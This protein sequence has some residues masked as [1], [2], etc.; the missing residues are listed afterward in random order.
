M[1]SHR[2]NPLYTL[3]RRIF[4]HLIP[5]IK[6]S[7]DNA[8][9]RI[10]VVTILLNL[11]VVC[12]V[13]T[14]RDHGS[15][16]QVLFHP[17]LRSDQDGVIFLT[18]IND[19]ISALPRKRSERNLIPIRRP[20]CIRRVGPHIIEGAGCEGSKVAC[21]NTQARTVGSVTVRQ[22]GIGRGVITNTP[23]GDR[24]AAVAGHVSAGGGRC[25]SDPGGIGGGDR[26]QI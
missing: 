24:R 15:H 25:G 9:R 1:P 26:R 2:A 11:A 3:C 23:G 16:I 19:C 7:V 18:L 4:H 21:E 8:I 22:G 12:L 10:I 20:I 13:L 6:A 14:S 17:A 5:L